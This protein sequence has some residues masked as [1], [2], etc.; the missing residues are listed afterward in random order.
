MKNHDNVRNLLLLADVLPHVT[1]LNL[2][3]QRRDCHLGQVTGQEEKTLKM[4]RR[5][6]TDDGPWLL[7]ATQIMEE[8]NI[9]PETRSENFQNGHSAF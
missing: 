2:F 5:R 4:L 7:K 1:A 6:K 8:C 3:F 9:T